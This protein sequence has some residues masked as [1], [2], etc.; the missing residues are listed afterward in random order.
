M[1]NGAEN[2]MNPRRKRFVVFVGG[3]R[4]VGEYDTKAEAIAKAETCISGIVDIRERTPGTY[5]NP[6]LTEKGDEEE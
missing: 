3:W 2:I 5:P 4:P 1:T 6:T